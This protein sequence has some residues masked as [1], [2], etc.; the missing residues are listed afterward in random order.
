MKTVY[1]ILLLC[2]GTSWSCERE[3]IDLVVV[4][5]LS[6]YWDHE[7]FGEGGR[8]LR[9]EFQETQQFDEDID[10]VFD[11]MVADDKV[12]IS[13]VDKIIVKDCPDYPSPNGVEYRCTPRGGVEIPDSL[14]GGKSY[15]LYL[16]TPT[17]EIEAILKYGST[18]E[19]SIL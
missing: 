17:F 16:Q 8:R 7:V 13:L 14:L 3:K 1:Y 9:F 5:D 10:L 4:E 2:I 18:M 6:L 15:A 12:I 19:K 11:Y